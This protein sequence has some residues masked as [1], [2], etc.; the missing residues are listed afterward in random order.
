[1]T[2]VFNSS[3]SPTLGTRGRLVVPAFVFKLKSGAA[4]R[5]HGAEFGAIFHFNV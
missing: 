4:K 3:T 1:M 2:D 5:R